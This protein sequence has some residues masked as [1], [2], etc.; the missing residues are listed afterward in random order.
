MSETPA[1][2]VLGLR[3]DGADAACGS[4]PLIEKLLFLIRE[5]GCGPEA[6]DELQQLGT[7]LDQ[8]SRTFLATTC[9]ST[10]EVT[11]PIV[12]I[13]TKLLDSMPRSTNTKEIAAALTLVRDAVASIDNVE[14]TLQRSLA[15]S[16][17]KFDA[18]RRLNDLHQV[19]AGLARNV[20]S[21]K[22]VSSKRERQWR[23]Q[24]SSVEQKVRTLET[25]LAES[26]L[27]AQHDALTGLVNRRSVE[28]SF[29]SFLEGHRQFVVALFDVDNFKR[30]NDT[31][32]HLAG[33]SA[34]KTIASIVQTSVRSHDVLG[35]YGGDEFILLMV[36]VSLPQ[37]EHRLR[38]IVQNIRNAPPIGGA[39]GARLTISCGVAE[40]SAGDTFE[41]LVA[42]ADQALYDVKRA[43]K[44]RIG[45]KT[46]PYIRGF[47][48]KANAS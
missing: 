21:L 41:S 48:K 14:Q 13:C 5:K 25:Q 18:L 7:R 27:A 45:I 6:A 22:M 9:K 10:P 26:R 33:D 17:D 29:K 16:V 32:G 38:G 37:A 46:T 28:T 1:R 8:L 24:M 4:Q 34:L 36:D 47:G 19:K 42:R 20:E 35:R 2:D 15:E 31:F 40:C 43:G 11:E 23:K 3:Y 12:E 39:N 44:N 30:I